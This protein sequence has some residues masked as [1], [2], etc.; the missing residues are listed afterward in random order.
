MALYK[1]GELIDSL[2]YLYSGQCD[3]QQ[4]PQ[5]LKA[6]SSCQQ[7][8]QSSEKHSLQG[9]LSNP[10]VNYIYVIDS[11]KHV[12]CMKYFMIISHI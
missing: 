9:N 12:I 4:T 2:L 5:I 7:P 6:I 8:G 3:S 10:A 11:Y 1:Q